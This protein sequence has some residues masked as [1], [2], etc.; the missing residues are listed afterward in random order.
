MVQTQSAPPRVRI[1]PFNTSG[2]SPTPVLTGPDD[3]PTILVLG[4]ISAPAA[5]SWWPGIA[6]PGCALDT[7]RVR[8]LGMSFDGHST[9][10]QAEHILRTLDD[11]GIDRLHAAVGCSYGGMV[12]LALAAL[13]PDRLQQLVVVAAAHRPHALAAGWRRVQQRIL[14]FADDLGAPEQG[15]A[16]ARMLAMTTYRGARGLDDRFDADSVGDWLDHHGRT[17]ASATSN[18]RYLRLSRAIDAHRVDPRDLVV[19]LTLIGFDSDQLA[20]PWL[21]AELAGRAAGPVDLHILPSPHGHDAFLL[22]VDALAAHLRAAVGV[23][24]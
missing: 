9:Q 19:P 23:S 20:P 13:A 12:C 10:Q 15:V 21:L 7:E 6:G 16:L 24:R 3:A 17:Y 11:L 4:G 5:P 2:T 8:L 18:A 22:E 1:D 14:A